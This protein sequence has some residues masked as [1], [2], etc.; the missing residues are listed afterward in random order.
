MQTEHTMIW[1]TA[2]IAAHSAGCVAIERQTISP[3]VLNCEA[4]EPTIL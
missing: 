1:H 2:D 4:S 3:E